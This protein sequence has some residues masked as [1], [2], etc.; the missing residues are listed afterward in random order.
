MQIDWI[1]FFAQIVNLF[2][3]M[4]ILNKLLYKPVLKVIQIRQDKINAKVKEA[5]DIKTAAL[6]LK[7]EY[8]E[9]IFSFQQER[10]SLLEKAQDDAEKQKVFLLDQAAD[11]VKRQRGKWVTRLQNEQSIFSNELKNLFSESFQQLA[12][13]ALSDLSSVSLEKAILL[14]LDEKIQKLSEQEKEN[15]RHAYSKTGQV[16]I[17]S[18]KELNAEDKNLCVELMK[19]FLKTDW[20][21][22]VY[23]TEDSLIGGIEI[24]CGEKALLWNLK[25]YLDSF[26]KQMEEAL[27]TLAQK[28]KNENISSSHTEEKQFSS[29][30]KK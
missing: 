16:I 9:K 13:N 4:W 26:S 19:K 24:L 10:Q 2:L 12:K 25:E 6:Q 5:Q 1:T 17:V 21:Q 28:E 7:K 11:D 20:P 29:F 27:L 14:K 8:E 3:L 22:I 23:K 15:F 30:D 18:D